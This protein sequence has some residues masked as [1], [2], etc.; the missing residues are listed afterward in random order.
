MGSQIPCLFVKLIWFTG[1]T[2]DP[3]R[4]LGHHWSTS[5]LETNHLNNWLVPFGFLPQSAMD[6]PYSK[7]HATDSSVR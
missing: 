5:V 3:Y 2:A 1:A 6:L 7:R 4:G